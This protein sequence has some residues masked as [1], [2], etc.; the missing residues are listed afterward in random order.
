MNKF[1]K[2]FLFFGTSFLTPFVAHADIID[3][4][5]SI[6]Q[7]FDVQRNPPY[8]VAGASFTL[9]NFVAPYRDN[10]TNYDIATGYISFFYTGDA[11]ALVGIRLYDS[12]G[13]LLETVSVKGDIYGLEPE[14]FLY[15]SD[16]GDYGTFVSNNQGFNYG[17]SVSY[18]TTKD[19]IV[20]LAELQ[21]YAANATPLGA[22]Q[23]AGG[24]GGGGTLTSAVA[25]FGSPSSLGAAQA[26]DNFLA[27]S[28]DATLI[29]AFGNLSTGSE[30]AE[31]VAQALPVAS[32]G[33]TSAIMSAV[34]N[35]L[36]IIQARSSSLSGLSSGDGF[37]SE[38]NMWLKPFYSRADQDNKGGVTGYDATSYG[39][40]IGYDSAVS[41]SLRLGAAVSYG[42]VE[43]DSN[44]GNQNVDVDS[45]EAMLYGSYVLDA[46]TE[47]NFIAGAGFFNSESRRHISF[48]GLNRTA[49][50]EYDSWSARVGAG[51]GRVI[52]ISPGLQVIPALRLDYSYLENDSYTETGAGT[53]NLRV[54]EQTAEQLI[55]EI[56]A[57]VKYNVND[58]LSLTGEAGVGYDVLTERSSVTSAFVGGGGAFT[59]SGIKASPWHI[60]S[61]VALEY[62]INDA[63]DLGI[64]Y[65][66]FDRGSDY[67]NQTVS[68]RA[69]WKF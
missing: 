9:S 65:D 21:A 26:L 64:H 36:Q 20:S 32:G 25:G 30:R 15:V 50:A 19:G 55:P 61:G 49:S 34:G 62:K 33:T 13:G 1:L 56:S 40:V 18:T 6:N 10:F 42:N 53:L 52:E 14:G 48:G 27:G 22:G 37:I 3:G 17:E 51:V 60:K 29:A 11:N 45:Y 23:M 39:G 38:G 59:T 54:D 2:N 46:T 16:D 43:I 44:A 41:E 58:N 67:D 35:S 66:R 7:V 63:V 12:N 57:K 68:A 28:G 47:L 5:Y 24:G 8:P 69:L 4:R 31:A